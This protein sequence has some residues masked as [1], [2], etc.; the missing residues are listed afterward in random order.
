M[1]AKLLLLGW[2]NES[3]ENDNVNKNDSWIVTKTPFVKQ[4]KQRLDCENKKSRN[5]PYISTSTHPFLN[6]SVQRS[7]GKAFR[8]NLTLNASMYVVSGSRDAAHACT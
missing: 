1:S 7:A 6:C 3:F 5:A 2:S 4:G 8:L